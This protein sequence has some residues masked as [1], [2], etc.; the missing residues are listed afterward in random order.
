MQVNRKKCQENFTYKTSLYTQGE[1]TVENC[2]EKNVETKS[3][4]F[5]YV[6]V[7]F[8]QRVDFFTLNIIK[9][10]NKP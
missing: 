2:E 5:L 6:N 9:N 7:E 4:I 3:L 8:S 1:K 10:D